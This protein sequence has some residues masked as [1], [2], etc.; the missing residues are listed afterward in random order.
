MIMTESRQTPDHDPHAEAWQQLILEDLGESSEARKP[1][2]D[3]MQE[4]CATVP[5]YLEAVKNTLAD[6]DDEDPEAKDRLREVVDPHSLAPTTLQDMP[7]EPEEA[8]TDPDF[9][10]QELFEKIEAVAAK[11]GDRGLKAWRETVEDLSAELRKAIRD[12]P[13]RAGMVAAWQDAYRQGSATRSAA[14]ETQRGAFYTKDAYAVEAAE[15]TDPGERPTRQRRPRPLTARGPLSRFTLPPTP[16]THSSG[17]VADTEEYMKAQQAREDYTRGVFVSPAIPTVPEHGK[18][19]ELAAAAAARKQA[20][21]DQDDG[22]Q[23]LH[24]S[25][26]DAAIRRKTISGIDDIIAGVK[27]GDGSSDRVGGT[28][29]VAYWRRDL[30]AEFL[31]NYPTPRQTINEAWHA[32]HASIEANGNEAA[33]RWSYAAMRSLGMQLNDLKTTLRQTPASHPS[34]EQMHQLYVSTLAGYVGSRYVS[35]MSRGLNAPP[36]ADGT[37][38]FNNRY[39]VTF[40][41]GK[42]VVAEDGRNAVMYP[43]GTLQVRDTVSGDKVRVQ[44]DGTEYSDPYPPIRPI[45]IPPDLSTD[46]LLDGY[47]TTMRHWFSAQADPQRSH[48]AS[49]YAAALAQRFYEESANPDDPDAQQKL[50]VAN[51]MSFWQTYIS[52]PVGDESPHMRD[53]LNK[54]GSV[55]VFDSHYG[56]FGWWVVCSDGS[57]KLYDEDIDNRGSWKLHASYDAQGNR[58]D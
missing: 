30:T 35:D 31:Q 56:E 14:A 26:V 49:A 34:Y 46:E 33:N 38:N 5:G 45:N 24:E 29:E 1:V 12:D 25:E 58:L 53:R 16:F 41:L 51:G 28:P 9:E 18:P 2:I 8:E 47:H 40:T 36:Q 10:L 52:L 23:S 32:V 57:M 54:D 37:R 3:A 6:T 43:D 4:R 21:Q 27:S 55:V 39:P 50:L 48:E 20:K 7:P 22:K 15:G 17:H 42:A 19:A 13:Q 11:K 44:P